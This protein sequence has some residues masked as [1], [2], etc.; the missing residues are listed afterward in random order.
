MEEID[1]LTIYGP[2]TIAKR[3]G[4]LSFNLRGIPSHALGRFLSDRGVAIR[5]GDHCTQPLLRSMGVSSTARAS[6]YLYNTEE[7]IDRFASL[8]GEAARLPRSHWS[9]ER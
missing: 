7:E 5:A 9:E 4:V 8:L 6:L 1:G 2:D 3:T